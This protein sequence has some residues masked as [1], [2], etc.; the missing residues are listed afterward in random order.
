MVVG[1]CRRAVY[2][3]RR[4]IA[5]ALRAR[6]DWTADLVDCSAVLDQ[7]EFRQASLLTLA[8]RSASRSG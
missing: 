1:L 7:W 3:L 6:R 4:I 2:L 5:L 8:Q